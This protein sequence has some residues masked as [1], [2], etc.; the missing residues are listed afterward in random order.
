MNFQVSRP[1]IGF[2]PIRPGSRV[3]FN[4][5][6]LQASRSKNEPKPCRKNTSKLALVFVFAPSIVK[7]FYSSVTFLQESLHIEF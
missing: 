3:L 7:S 4:G 6:N 5:Q 1:T 2:E